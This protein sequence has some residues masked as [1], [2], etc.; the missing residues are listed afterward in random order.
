LAVASRNDRLFVIGY[1]SLLSGYGLV[2][3]RRKAESRL[4]A[5]DAE[6]VVLANAKRGLAKW[7][8]HGNYFAMDIEPVDRAKPITGHPARNG[9]AGIGAILLTFDRSASRKIARREEYGPDLFEK[10]L[11]LADRTGLSVGEFLV[12]VAE[13]TNHDLLAYRTALRA[14]VGQTSPGYI[15]HPVALDDG[16]V[17]IIA[18]GSGFE[19]S[20]DPEVISWRRHYGIER[21][22]ALGEALA[23]T[24]F[25]ID[26]AGQFEYIAECLL[27]G[28]HGIDV[29]DLIEP[30][31]L[32][33]E[34]ARELIG[35]IAVAAEGEAARF[36]E[37]TSLDLAGY[38]S[39]FAGVPIASFAQ[40]LSL[41]K[42]G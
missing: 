26:R 20:G 31:D 16:R 8:S 25:E 12:R 19:G 2:G 7:S 40:L 33:S 24:R 1:G 29:S 14:L 34:V 27:G 4:Y 9:R 37:A 42:L 6:P 23:M 22:M 13:E 18:I 32:K 10:L 5:L 30:F 41:A 21:V 11:A 36:A 39:R 38:Q 17:A 28:F 3:P 15:F 35:R